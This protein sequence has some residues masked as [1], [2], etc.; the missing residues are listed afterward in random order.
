MPTPIKKKRRRK[1]QRRQQKL[2]NKVAKATL[3]AC[4]TSYLRLKCPFIINKTH[5]IIAMR[6]GIHP[7]YNPVVFQDISTGE[8]FVTRSTIRT[9]Q[10]IELEGKEY[11]LVRVE[12]SCSSHPF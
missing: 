7:K 6:E 5:R 12:V 10:K 1:K 9:T 4:I 2:K 3:N 11:G 8:M